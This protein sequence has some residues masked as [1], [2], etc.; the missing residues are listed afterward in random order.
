M[1]PNEEAT[2]AEAQIVRNAEAI[3]AMTKKLNEVKMALGPMLPHADLILVRFIHIRT[4]YMSV[5]I[6]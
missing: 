1:D 5:F 2:N 3:I 4:L 6:S